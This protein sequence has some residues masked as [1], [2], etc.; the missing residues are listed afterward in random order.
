MTEARLGV[1]S[2]QEGTERERA[3]P[4]HAPRGQWGP[5]RTGWQSRRCCRPHCL[6]HRQ[7]PAAWP[8]EPA[9][10]RANVVSG[11]QTRPD[12][13]ALSSRGGPALCGALGRETRSRSPRA[14]PGAE[15]CASAPALL[16]PPR[17]SRCCCRGRSRFRS[18]EL[19]PCRWRRPSGSGRRASGRRPLPLAGRQRRRDSG[20]RGLADSR[21]RGRAAPRASPRRARRGGAR[22]R[23]PWGR[24]SG[25][26][27]RTYRVSSTRRKKTLKRKSINL[28]KL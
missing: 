20:T 27:F 12:P 1:H 16:R 18:G 7:R 22:Q 17:P 5:R 2:V 3:A 15:A 10:T 28:R 4:R 13:Q 26:R 6:E 23:R 19:G 11:E 25:S 9:G 14:A 8:L 21:T 24:A